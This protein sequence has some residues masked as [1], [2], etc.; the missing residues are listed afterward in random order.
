MV[1]DKTGI[2]RTTAMENVSRIMDTEQLKDKPGADEVLALGNEELAERAQQQG[3]YPQEQSSGDGASNP[4]K[5]ASGEGVSQPGSFS[6][7]A[8]EGAPKEEFGRLKKHS[9]EERPR[10][11]QGK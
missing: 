9:V 6:T 3:A 10:S 7:G 1:K 2:S 5:G 4:E 8:Q 11:K